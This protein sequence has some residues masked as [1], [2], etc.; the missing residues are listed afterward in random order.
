MLII[1]RT[2]HKGSDPPASR[3]ASGPFPGLW[4]VRAIAPLLCLVTGPVCGTT[5]YLLG[6]SPILHSRHHHRCAT[7]VALLCPHFPDGHTETCVGSVSG[8]QTW[9]I[10]EL[11]Q[12]LLIMG[13]RGK[14]D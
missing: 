9:L 2:F 8:S 3:T 13:G 5:I 10:S 12:G 4:E 11:P 1:R 7:G 14:S 6:S